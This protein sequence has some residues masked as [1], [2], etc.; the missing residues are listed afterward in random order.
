[1]KNNELKAKVIK[2]Y[3]DIKSGK[4]AGLKM[5]TAKTIKIG[6]VTFIID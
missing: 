6:S 3:N 5:A 1:M 4:V 2:T